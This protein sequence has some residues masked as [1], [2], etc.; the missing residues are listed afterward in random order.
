MNKSRMQSSQK[1]TTV[2]LFK[3]KKVCNPKKQIISFKCS[4]PRRL[5]LSGKQ[6]LLS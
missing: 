4:P 5:Q 1:F 6:E 2:L 3:T